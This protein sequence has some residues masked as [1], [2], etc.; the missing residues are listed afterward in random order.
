MTEDELPRA[1]GVID[2]FERDPKLVQ[3][4]MQAKGAAVMGVLA[5]RGI[6]AITAA[7]RA[8]KAEAAGEPLAEAVCALQSMGLGDFV[9]VDLTI[10][11]GLAYYTGAVFELFDAKR[12]LRAIC[13]GG[14][15]DDLLKQVGGVD[16]PCVGFGMGDVVLGELVEERDGPPKA[17]PVVGVFVA[18]VGEDD[19]PAALALAHALRDRGMRVEFVLKRQAL[20][21]QLELAAA[22][23]ARAAVVLGPEERA[24]GQAIVRTLASGAERRVPLTELAG[25]YAF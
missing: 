9:E 15:Y 25:D 8:V 16:L 19:R 13:G 1:F 23:G 18:M 10:V 11:R 6:E 2:K 22:R 21:K 4:V 7:L 12:S 20:G 14:R 5:L 17:E 3:Q 24:A